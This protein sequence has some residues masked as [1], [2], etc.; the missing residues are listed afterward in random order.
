MAHKWSDDD[1]RVALYLYRFPDDADP[2]LSIDDVG[3]KLGMGPASLKMRIRNF[4][5]VD[6][7]YE[8]LRNRAKRTRR[9]YAEHIGTPQ[10]ELRAIVLQFL[11]R[12]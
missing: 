1:E 10:T 8:G 6:T 9:V 11:S 4:L 5:W 3:E 7:G 12:R 2:L